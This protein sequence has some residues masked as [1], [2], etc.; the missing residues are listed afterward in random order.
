M[1]WPD[2]SASWVTPWERDW[3][4]SR[5]FFLLLL[6]LAE[7]G[8]GELHLFFRRLGLHLGDGEL[9]TKGVRLGAE[10]FLGLTKYFRLGLGGFEGG[11]GAF[12]FGLGLLGQPGGLLLAFLEALG[13]FGGAGAS[14]VQDGGAGAGLVLAGGE[15]SGEF[16]AV[17]FFVLQRKTE[18]GDDIVLGETARE[19]TGV[20]GGASGLSQ[21]VRARRLRSRKSQRMRRR[22]LF[23][24]AGGNRARGFPFRF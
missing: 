14:L 8:G 11:A 18:G 16:L 3:F 10:L 5:S 9:G 15:V 20:G 6:R 12:R 13:K 7:S 24:V 1:I 4:C 19:V 23:T 21:R 17:G 2:F 22:V